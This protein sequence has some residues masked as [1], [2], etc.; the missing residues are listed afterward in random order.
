MKIT[1]ADMQTKPP[2]RLLYRGFTYVLAARSDEGATWEKTV[3]PIQKM[4]QAVTDLVEDER[5][6]SSNTQTVARL[7]GELNEYFKLLIPR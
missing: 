1:S 6:I 2:K 5:K 7:W 3:E 4:L